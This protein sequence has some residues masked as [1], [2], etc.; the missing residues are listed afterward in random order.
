MMPPGQP[1]LKRGLFPRIRRLTVALL[2]CVSLSCVAELSPLGVLEPDAFSDYIRHFNSMEDE[3]VTNLISNAEAPAWLG[4]NIPLFEC[5]D[6]QVQEIYYFRWWSFRKHLKQT[7]KGYMF[8]EFLTPV[9]HAGECN[10]VSC[11]A[12]FHVAEGRWLRDSR[13][14]EDTILFWLRGNAGQ[15]QPHFH[16]FSSWFA[17]AV[18]ER[19]LV[20]HDREFVTGLLGDLVADYRVWEQE[21]QLPNGLFWQYDVRDGMEESISGSR[22]AQQAR[23]TINSYMVANA[24]AIRHIAELAGQSALAEEFREKA[25]TLRQLTLAQLWNPD[26]AFFEVRH[27]ETGFANVREAIGFIPWRHGLP[28]P[29][30]GY[31]AAWGQLMDPE[32]FCAPFGITTAERRHPGFRTHGV[33]TCE[34]DGAVWPFATTQTLGAM[35]TVL[36]DYPQE[37]VD[38][39]DYLAQFLTYVVS[40]YAGSKPYIGEYL[41]EVTGDWINGKGGRSRYYNHSTFADLLITGVVGLR[42]R[43]DEVVEIS[44]LLPAGAWDYFC[45]DGVRY[46][47]H[48]LTI[49]WDKDGSRYGRGQ[50]LVVLADGKEIARGKRLSKLTGKLP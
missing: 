36:R 5:P 44:P 1:D 39:E 40:Q 46:H 25:A 13:F 29:D 34:W 20:H 4:D 45:L 50:G 11:A 19:Y 26:Q 49:L 3:N 18:Y 42:P 35:A 32:G 8:T 48:T 28:V 38:R 24:R 43:A 30:S 14:V 12:A 10:S 16:K 33:G 47:G 9:G 21:R 23:P 15:P 37:H 6:S 7:P 31:E 17:A 2:A 27:P 41:D 22:R